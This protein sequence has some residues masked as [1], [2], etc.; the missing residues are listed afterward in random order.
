MSLDELNARLEN[1]RGEWDRLKAR[2]EM[3]DQKMEEKS[4]LEDKYNA[5]EIDQTYL[6]DSL[7][8]LEKKYPTSYEDQLND[9][10][11]YSP[12]SIGDA[13]AEGIEDRDK[14]LAQKLNLKRNNNSGSNMGTLSRNWGGSTQSSSGGAM[15]T[16]SP[17]NPQAASGGAMNSIQ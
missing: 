2:E 7:A 13:L 16:P 5:G 11:G 9:L 10:M 1:L 3:Q 8:A 17:S 14:A 4:D 6:G 12:D 15:N